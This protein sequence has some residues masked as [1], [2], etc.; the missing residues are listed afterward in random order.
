MCDQPAV[1]AAVA[2]V[3]TE[4]G[5]LD[6]VVCNAGVATFATI[7]E[8]DILDARTTFETNFWGSVHVMRA[9]LPA[10][11]RQVAA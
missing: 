8:H 9:A 7:E 4:A 5:R 10:M 6:V 3:V 2:A 11:R 1:D